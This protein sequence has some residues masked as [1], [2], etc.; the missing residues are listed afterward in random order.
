MD[1]IVFQAFPVD[2]SLLHAALQELEALAEDSPSEGTHAATQ[3]YDA[4]Y[5][6]DITYP[7]GSE[8]APGSEFIKTWRVAN[9]GVWTWNE[10]VCVDVCMDFVI[11]F[12]Q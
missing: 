2:A 8:V 11:S 3:G 7:D 9:T 4:R 5:V 12:A 1:D 10:K 6:K